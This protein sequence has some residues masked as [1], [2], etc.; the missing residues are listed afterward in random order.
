[1]SSSTN[2]FQGLDS[3]YNL[4]KKQSSTSTPFSDQNNSSNF[5]ASIFSYK[6]SYRGTFNNISQLEGYQNR[7]RER[8]KQ[9]VAAVIGGIAMIVLS[10]AL[11]Y[12]TKNYFQADKELKKAEEFKSIL[13]TIAQEEGFQV[14]HV[15]PIV[16]KHIELVENKR[17]QSRNIMVITGAVLAAATGAFLGG[18]LAVSWLITASVIVGVFAA[19]TGAFLVVCHW[20]DETSLPSDMQT[21][22]KNFLAAS[23]ID[24]EKAI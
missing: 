3:Y 20:D 10:G 5:L 22:I 9:N 15:L 13:P 2:F 18:M 4:S 12:V 17:S 23:N 6:E 14:T 21:Q 19:A 16:N 8:S 1:M 24:S 7:E 11:A